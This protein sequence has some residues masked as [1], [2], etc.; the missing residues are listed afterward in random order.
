MVVVVYASI[1][2]AAAGD[3]DIGDELQDDWIHGWLMIVAK[4]HPELSLCHIVDGIERVLCIAGN[5][6][7]NNSISAWL[8]NVLKPRGGCIV[9]SG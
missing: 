4:E 3:H 8:V 2:S 9:A 1:F 5:M 7:H 6:T